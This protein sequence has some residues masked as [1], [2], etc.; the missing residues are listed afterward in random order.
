MFLWGG[1]WLLPGH[2]SQER[3]L[4]G[5]RRG[6]V[7]LTDVAMSPTTFVRS[8]DR[9]AGVLLGACRHGYACKEKYSWWSPGR[10]SGKTGCLGWPEETKGTSHTDLGLSG[11]EATWKDGLCN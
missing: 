1:S 4:G 6:P 10:A 3:E 2:L 7:C 5:S 8:R 11:W 9:V